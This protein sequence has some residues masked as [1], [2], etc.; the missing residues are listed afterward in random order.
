MFVYMLARGV[1]EGYL[2]SSFADIAKAGSLGIMNEFMFK[3]RGI[4]M[5]VLHG[6]VSVSGL[7]GSPYRD[8]SYAYYTGEKVVDNDPKGI[9]AAD[10]GGR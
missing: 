9:G 4:S 10:D 5:P 7:G 3:V 2:P 1:Q 6:T 8:G